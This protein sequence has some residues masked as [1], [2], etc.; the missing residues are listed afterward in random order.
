MVI[1]CTHQTRNDMQPSITISI[2]PDDITKIDA[3]ILALKYAQARYGLDSYVTDR[4]IENGIDHKKTSPKP[5]GFRLLPSPPDITATNVLIVGVVP[6]REFDYKNIRDFGRKILSSLAGANPEI[7]HI[8]VTVHGVGYGLDEKEAFESQLAGF[9]DAIRSGDIPEKLE[10]IT[11]AERNPGR[12][13]RL[14]QHLKVIIP[15]EIIEVDARWNIK[16]VTKDTHEKLREVGYTSNLKK[17]VFVA[18]PFCEDME[19]IYDYGISTAV[20]NAGYLCERADLSSYTGDVMQWVRDR[21]KSASLVIGDLTGSNPNVY[22]EIGYAWGCGVNTVLLI[23]NTKELK[24]DVQ[25][26]RCITYNRIK[27]V[28]EKLGTELKKI[29]KSV[30]I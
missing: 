16:N 18:M 11:F 7:R 13:Y 17:H 3:D 14:E 12:Q 27:D 8:V 21:I 28:E 9:I 19:D 25:G 26:Q 6:L 1:C 10:R 29:K 2:V 4:L 30:N 22:L 15:N 20:R 24:F 5:G 23:K